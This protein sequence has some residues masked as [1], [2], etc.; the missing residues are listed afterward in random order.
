MP[1]VVRRR[2][3]GTVTIAAHLRKNLHCAEASALVPAFRGPDPARLGWA[4]SLTREAQQ[5][6]EMPWSFASQLVSEITQLACVAVLHVGSSL[7]QSA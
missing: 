2:D 7:R 1:V 4:V 6:E 5:L 3:L